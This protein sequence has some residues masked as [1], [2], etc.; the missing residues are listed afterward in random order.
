MSGRVTNIVLAGIGGQGVVTASD[1]LATV[2]FEAGYDVKKSEIHGMSQRGGSVSSDIR[3]GDKVWS[4]M[5]PAGRADFLVI[6]EE[7]QLDVNRARL[8]PEGVLITPDLLEGLVAEDDFE[9]E[10]AGAI[11][12]QSMNIALLGVLSGR[13]EI[14]PAVWERVIREKLPEQAH[15]MNLAAFAKG[16]E[17]AHTGTS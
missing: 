17:L 10:E 16:R 13:L 4:P 7:T 2:A 8:G 1:I 15:E 5:V 11:A 9:A 12:P 6:L 3:F 14:D